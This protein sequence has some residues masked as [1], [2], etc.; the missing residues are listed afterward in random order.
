LPPSAGLFW[1]GLRLV[2]ATTPTIATTRPEMARRVD[3]SI[4]E[5]LKHTQVNT[6]IR[7]PAGEAGTAQNKNK[8]KEITEKDLTAHIDN[9]FYS[10]LLGFSLLLCNFFISLSL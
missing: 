4:F 8:P 9:F 6:P 5:A 7:S 2:A 1:N 3:P 10:I